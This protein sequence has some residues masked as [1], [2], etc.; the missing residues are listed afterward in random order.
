MIYTEPSVL[1]WP[2]GEKTIL[3]LADANKYILAETPAVEVIN[4]VVKGEDIDSIMHFCTDKF[5]IPSEQAEAFVRN[6]QQHLNEYL[7]PEILPQKQFA[8]PT[9][10]QQRPVMV[11][12]KYYLIYGISFFVEYETKE[13]ELLIHPKF[14][15]LEVPRVQSPDHHFQVFNSNNESSLWVD[16]VLIGTWN[17]ND[18][19]FLSGKFSMQVIQKIYQ[20]EEN[21]WMAVFHAAGITN[22]ESCLIFLGDS[23]NGKSTL[24]AILMANGLEVLADDFLPVESKSGLVCHFPAAISVKNNALELLIPKFPQLG[25]AKEVN[26]NATGKTFRYLANHRMKP[27]RVPCKAL[28]FVRY[29]KDAGFQFEKM[30]G[31]EAFSHLVPD[32]W[33]S[34][35]RENAQQFVEWFTSLLCYRMTYSDNEKMVQT[36]KKLLN[37][38]L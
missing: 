36:V 6:I 26:N 27:I 15:H 21:E 23:G 16:E 30:S 22:G 18:N 7:Q 1:S 29:V 12:K 3:W 33:I 4:R 28:V 9:T 38:D 32:S 25:Y 13:A 2:F 20:Q 5:D 19:H 10:I 14:E 24:S 35:T 34:P 11:S 8:N 31:E 17:W 37:N